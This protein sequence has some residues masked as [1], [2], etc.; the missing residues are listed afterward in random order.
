MLLSRHAR[1]VLMSRADSTRRSAAVV[2]IHNLKRTI[3]NNTTTT[4][5]KQITHTLSNNIGVSRAFLTTAA[6]TCSVPRRRRAALTGRRDCGSDCD[7]ERDTSIVLP[8][9]RTHWLHGI[10][11]RRNIVLKNIPSAAS[12]L[13]P[14][15][16]CILAEMG[17]GDVL[18][19]AD[20]N[21]PAHSTHEQ[22]IRADG[23]TATQVLDAVLSLFPLDTFVDSPAS[24]MQMVDKPDENAPIYAEF[25]CLLDQHNG[26]CV[27][28]QKLERFA[29]YEQAKTAYAVVSCGEKRLY[30]NIMIKKGVIG[31]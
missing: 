31:E 28:V 22:V 25:Q 21:F 23:N 27:N 12:I 16:L 29:F 7:S 30:G 10:V 26:S 3:Q 2:R 24:V 15:L 14:E 19:I 4:T 11:P 5:T 20:A 8:F 9:T 13:S 1:R 6:A 18:V 17:H